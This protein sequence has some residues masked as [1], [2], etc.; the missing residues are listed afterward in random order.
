ME[1]AKAEA[2]EAVQTEGTTQTGNVTAEGTKQVQA[3]QQAAQEIVA[4]RKQIQQNKADVTTLKKD[5]AQ[6]LT[7]EIQTTNLLYLEDGTLT[8]YGV[9]ITVNDGYIKLSGKSTTNGH[10]KISNGLQGLTSITDWFSEQVEGFSSG[11]S[12]TFFYVLKKGTDLPTFVRIYDNDTNDWVNITETSTT[13]ISTRRYRLLI[14]IVK[15]GK[16]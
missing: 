9:T 4:D 11:D 3:V 6:V 10:F 12:A 16:Q 7:E 5:L 8:K 13:K 1:E 15:M 2:I 14:F